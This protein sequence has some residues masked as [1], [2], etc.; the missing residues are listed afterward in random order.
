MLAALDTAKA[1]L[2]LFVPSL[3]EYMVGA[4]PLGWVIVAVSVAA[5]HLVK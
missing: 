5:A 4:L 1:V 2:G 3:A